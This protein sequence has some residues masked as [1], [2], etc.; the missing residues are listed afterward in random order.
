MIIGITGKSGVGKTTYCNKIAKELNLY[1]IHIDEL[2]HSVFEENDIKTAFISTFGP[3][4]LN[5]DGTIN[6]KYAGDKIFENRKIY[7]DLNKRVWIRLQEVVWD[8]IN[9]HPN[10]V[11]DWILLPH[12]P[13]WKKC[14]TKILISAD[15][16]SRVE[17]V[18]TRDNISLDYFNK[19]ESASI[20]Y[21]DCD[22]DKYIFNDYHTFH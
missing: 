18:L 12:S 9:T 2:S 22:F 20:E 19:R 17:K 11:L 16:R 21:D 4:I 6:R 10:C 3:N 14:D 8:E 15:Y 13:F 5:P 7:K 1:P